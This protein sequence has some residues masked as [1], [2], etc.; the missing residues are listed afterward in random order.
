MNYLQLGEIKEYGITS[1]SHEKRLLFLRQP[2]CFLRNKKKV[3]V[4]VSE[5]LLTFL[6]MES[7]TNQ[8]VLALDLS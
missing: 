8:P 3:N 6:L 2:L 5:D 4:I 1:L 7:G